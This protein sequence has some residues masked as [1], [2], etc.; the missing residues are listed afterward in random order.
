MKAKKATRPSGPSV[1]PQK[2]RDG[3]WYYETRRGIE[4]LQEL[5]IDGRRYTTTAT[6]PWTRLSAERSIAK[7]SSRKAATR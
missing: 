1:E 6:I 5:T 3:S 2:M 4:V 7:R